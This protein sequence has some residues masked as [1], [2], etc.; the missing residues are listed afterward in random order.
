MP[1]TFTYPFVDDDAT[2]Y[3]GGY[4]GPLRAS[5][6]PAA[7]SGAGADILTYADGKPVINPWTTQPYERPPGFDMQRNLLAGQAIKDN[8]EYL[9]ATGDP[10]LGRDAMFAPLFRPGGD[11]DY[12]RP[13][14]FSGPVQIRYR[15]IGYYNYGVI[16]AKAGYGKTE[17]LHNAG[18]YNRIFGGKWFGANGV[19]TLLGH[20]PS[21]DN[22][23]GLNGDDAR[24]FIEQGYDDYMNGLWTPFP[25]E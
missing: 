13:N 15:P 2:G 3:F 25:S 23:Y 1:G 11:M 19:N 8:S 9:L 17:A 21:F 18:L 22:S 6:P 5:D 7:P 14:G 20:P 4:R 16:A 10:P 24:Q 12:Q